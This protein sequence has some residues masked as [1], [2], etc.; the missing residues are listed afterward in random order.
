MIVQSLVKRRKKQ[1]MDS[2]SDYYG[3]L[4]CRFS[5]GFLSIGVTIRTCQEIQCLPS[6]GFFIYNLNTAYELELTL[7]TCIVFITI[8]DAQWTR[9]RALFFF[10]FFSFFRRTFLSIQSKYQIC[11]NRE[12]PCKAKYFEPFRIV[13]NA[14]TNV[15][16]TMKCDQNHP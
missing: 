16:E 6:A 10:F 2:R 8:F 12:T 14:K 5:L 1:K 4:V 7:P 9:K 15:F 3:L 11:L 13:L